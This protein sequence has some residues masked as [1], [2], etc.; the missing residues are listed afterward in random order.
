MEKTSELIWQDKQHQTLFKLIDEINAKQV[1]ITVFRRLSDYAENHFLLEEEY[2]YRLKYPRTQE[3]V[4]AHNRFRDE[5]ESM[6]NNYYSF[7]E[8]FRE[9]LTVFLS[10]WLKKHIYGIDKDLEDFVL[11][12]DKK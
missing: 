6:M 4:D 12:S 5:L 10:E 2:M 11:K 8:P 3:H 1:D 9:T 7:D